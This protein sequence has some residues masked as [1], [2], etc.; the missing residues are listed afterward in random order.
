MLSRTASSFLRRSATRCMSTEAAT[1]VKLNFCL[2]Q[3]TLYKGASVHSV[4]LPGMGGEYGITANH[5]PYVSQL[6]P[7]VVKILHEEGSADPE[8]YFVAGGYALTHPDSTTDV[9]CPEAVKLDD[10]D[11]SE[12]AKKYDAAR[13]KFSSATAGSIE[14]AEAQIE[15]EITKEMGMAIGVSLN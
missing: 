9:I 10:I 5:V 7:G 2:P 1:A 4:I 12:V 13:T 11:P 8:K 6:K 15:M 14:Q 3:E